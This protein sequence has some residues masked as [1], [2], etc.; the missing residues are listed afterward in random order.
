[1]AEP[2]TSDTLRRLASVVRP[3]P[4]YLIYQRYDEAGMVHVAQAHN[5][6]LLASR[7]CA[8]Y[9]EV[10][11]FEVAAILPH[12]QYLC[13]IQ[14]FYIQTVIMCHRNSNR[15]HPSQNEASVKPVQAISRPTISA[16]GQEYH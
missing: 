15:T 4:E 7:R 16:H 9:V 8:R 14:L 6:P 12:Q 1:M 2:V 10:G 5:W 13:I 3:T 11:V